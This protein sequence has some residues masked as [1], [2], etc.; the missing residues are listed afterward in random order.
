MV[1]RVI[2]IQLAHANNG[3][4]RWINNHSQYID[5]RRGMILWW[6]D[7]IDEKAS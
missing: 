6:A 3:S 5:K 7:W 4:V 2:E 1:M